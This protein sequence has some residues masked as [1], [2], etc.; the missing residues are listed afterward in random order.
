MV[1]GTQKMLQLAEFAFRLGSQRWSL[2]QSWQL[3]GYLK[4]KICPQ[5]WGRLGLFCNGLLKETEKKE[6]HFACPRQSG[7]LCVLELILVLILN[8][9]C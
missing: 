5:K 6:G 3:D 4:A 8:Y 2:S 9:E 7:Q 1:A